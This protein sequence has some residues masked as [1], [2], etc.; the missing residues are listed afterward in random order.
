M[1]NNSSNSYNLSSVTKSLQQN[2]AGMNAKSNIVTPLLWIFLPT[3]ASTVA[4][5]IWSKNSCVTIWL[6]CIISSVVFTVI[7]IYVYLICKD[8]LY[9]L[10]SEHYDL[11]SKQMDSKRGVEKIE[12]H[13]QFKN[14]D[15]FVKSA[16]GEKNE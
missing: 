16:D 10:R 13:P 8:K 12:N 9:L 3:L 1:S 4:S 7:G 2:V 5:S 14:V 6:L 15:D 11:V